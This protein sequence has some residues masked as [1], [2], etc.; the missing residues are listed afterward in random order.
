MGLGLYIT[1]QIV[2]AHGG[3]IGVTSA[4]GAGATFTVDLPLQALAAGNGHL[5]PGAD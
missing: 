1:R 5:P 4:P 3:A 2:E